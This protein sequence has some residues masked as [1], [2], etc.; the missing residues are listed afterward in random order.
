[1]SQGSSELGKIRTS[2]LHQSFR[3]PPDMSKLTT[4]ILCGQD[5][6]CSIWQQESTLEMQIVV[7]KIVTELGIMKWGHNKFKSG[8]KALL[9]RFNKLFLHC[10]SGY[11][12]VWSVSRVHINLILNNFWNLFALYIEGHVLGVPN[13]PFLLTS[14]SRDWF[15]RTSRFG[16]GVK[17]DGPIKRIERCC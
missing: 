12:N 7:F 13:S 6:L 16:S 5:L 14:L 2:S 10:L 11:C 15:W 3:E 8:H 17:E 4:T 1:M 9:R